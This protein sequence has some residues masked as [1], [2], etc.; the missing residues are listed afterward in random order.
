MTL[1]SASATAPYIQVAGRSQ[2]LIGFP[3]NLNVMHRL[4][5][6]M[7]DTKIRT[8]LV[9][10]DVPGDSQGG[11]QGDPIE[12]QLLAMRMT[13]EFNLSKWDPIVYEKLKRH[14]TMAVD[15]SFSLAET[16]ALLLRDR[17]FRIVISPSKNTTI[18]VTDPL[19]G[20]AHPDAGKDYHYYNFCCCTIS[21]PIAIG[22]G[23]KFSA[24]Q[25]SMRAFR[26]PEGHALA[27]G[28]GGADWANGLIWN[29]STTGVA[30]A[31]LPS[32]MDV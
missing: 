12:Q 6:Q 18:P 4:G 8:E 9:T 25:F 19:T 2:L 26:V 28:S 24:L 32:N 13:A 1:P 29:R 31:Y 14:A 27:P 22:Q 5:E 16:G 30:N 17:S 11:P 15:G 21:S 3:G 7:D 10:H 23:T 20:D